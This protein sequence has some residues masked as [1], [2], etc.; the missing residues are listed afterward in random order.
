MKTLIEVARLRTIVRTLALV[1]VLSLFVAVAS[2]AQPITVY[3]VPVSVDE[4]AT[5]AS[6]RGDVDMSADSLGTYYTQ[7]MVFGNIRTNTQ[8]IRLVADDIT[9]GTEDIDVFIEGSVDRKTWDAVSTAIKTNVSTTV[10]VDT[11]NVVQGATPIPL[12]SA[13]WIRLKFV[14]Q[15][16]NTKTVVH[17]STMGIKNTGSPALGA[18]AVANRKQ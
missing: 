17:W 15:T 7:A 10:G 9:G 3:D 12:T 13:V 16:G 14:G 2:H 6:Y 4:G 1:L 8:L 11:L 18:L 5:Y